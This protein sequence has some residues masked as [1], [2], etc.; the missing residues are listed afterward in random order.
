MHCYIFLLTQLL[1]DKRQANLLVCSG[2]VGIRR[3]FRRSRCRSG[4]ASRLRENATSQRRSARRTVPSPPLF[5]RNDAYWCRHGVSKSSLYGRL[6]SRAAA[7]AS[8]LSSAAP[9]T[10]LRSGTR[11]LATGWPTRY[12]THCQVCSSIRHLLDIAALPQLIYESQ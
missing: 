2:A 5:G 8:P 1:T 7:S 11:R 3:H 6:L 4:G 12:K 9:D 10:P